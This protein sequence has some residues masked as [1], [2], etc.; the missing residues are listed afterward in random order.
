MPIEICLP[1]PHPNQARILGE[2][3][4][5]NVVNCGRRWGKTTMGINLAAEPALQGGYVGWFVPEYKLLIEVWESLVEILEPILAKTDVVQKRI[6]LRTRGLIECWSFDRSPRAG[7]SRRYHRIIFD[8]AAHTTNLEHCWTQ[9]VRPTLTDFQG[10]AWFLSSPNGGNYFKQLYD[11]GQAGPSNWRS[12]TQTSYDNPFLDASEIDQ[13]RD[14]LPDAIYRQEYLAEFLAQSHQQ[15]IPDDWIGRCFVDGAARPS[16]SRAISA[17]ISKGTGRDRT[18]ILVTDD[19]GVLDL[20]VSSTTSIQEAAGLVSGLARQW[21][22]AHD[23]I[24]YDAGGWA[25]PDM[26]RYLEGLGIYS[27][28]PYLGSHPG[29]T[30]YTNRRSRSAWALRQ[31]LDPERPA[32][33]ITSNPSQPYSLIDRKR[34]EAADR[35]VGP[36]PAFALPASVIGQH[37]QAI[38]RELAELRYGYKAHKLELETKEALVGRLGHSPDLADAFIM[39]GS[40]WGD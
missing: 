21:G 39:T 28:L 3:A 17:D 1:S 27:A 4:R 34:A 18:V 6:K 15:L 9:A 29:G 36:R 26:G 2:A 33:T 14:E 30:R 8:E 35:L 23:R 19:A 10:D 31:R 16:G 32:I 37:G 5:F 20:V 22:V 11:R 13:A 38:R 7:R 40:L 25:G 12:W 24:V